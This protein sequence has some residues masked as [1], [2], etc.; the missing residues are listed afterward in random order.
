MKYFL[1]FLALCA[2]AGCEFP[3]KGV[4]ETAAPPFISQATATPILIDVNHLASQPTDP[5]DTILI[6]SASVD[7]RAVNSS[8]SY[9]AFDPAGNILLSGTLLDDGVP[10]D[11]I[12]DDGKFAGS[13]HLHI[14][15]QDVGTYGLQFQATNTSDF[16][17]NTLALALIIKNSN[18]HR[19]NISD[20]A[21]QD[22]VHIPPIGNTTFVKITLAVSDSEGLGDIVSVKLTSQRPNGTTAA[23]INL[24]DDGSS[25][26]YFQFGGNLTSGDLTAN[27]GIYTV[28]IPFTK[29]PD[30]PETVPTYRDFSFRATDRTGE[31]SNVI[32]KRIYIVQ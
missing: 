9:V 17:S 25:G 11:Q 18:N 15:K 7:D 19:P 21:M 24:Y 20:L 10:P 28:T 5:I 6:F 16:R 4:I 23:Q 29:A 1:S 26:P 12:A 31:F 32:T 30:P 3:D 13:A 22:T 2:I 27:D 8:V 14:L